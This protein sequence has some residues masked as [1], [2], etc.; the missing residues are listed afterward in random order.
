MPTQKKY[1]VTWQSFAFLPTIFVGLTIVT[2]Q[3]LNRL[4]SGEV[5][6]VYIFAPLALIYRF[7][8]YWPTVLLPPLVGI[9]CLVAL[10]LVYFNER[11]NDRNVA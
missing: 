11:R 6:S 3:Q 7:L 8:G 2:V 10:I 4:E 1:N 9:L 5:A